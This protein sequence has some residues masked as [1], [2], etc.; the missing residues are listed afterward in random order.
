M[1]KK[2]STLA[3]SLL[4]TSAFSVNAQVQGIGYGTVHTATPSGPVG[5]ETAYRTQ[6]TLS[7][8]FDKF[9]TDDTNVDEYN[10][11]TVNKIESEKW[12][13]LQVGEEDEVLVQLRDYTTGELYLKVV[14]QKS[15]TTGKK[16]EGNPTLTS[17]LW[18]IEVQDKGGYQRGKT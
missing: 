17:S 11:W 8:V 4:L 14:P 15:L 3:V 6:L 12:Y 7:D 16:P 5:G 10:K 9:G 1:N 2:F 18:K 13:Q